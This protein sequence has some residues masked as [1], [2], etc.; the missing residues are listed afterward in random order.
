[1]EFE[2]KCRLCGVSDERFLV[3]SH[4]KPWG[5]S[6]HQERLDSNNGLLLC[7]NHEALFDK[8]YISFDENGIILISN[9]LDEE[10]KVFLNTNESMNIT[11]SERQQKYIKWYQGNIYNYFER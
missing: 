9:S 11:L 2:K 5:Q 10:T 7:L 3:A 4:I 8:G 1:M 6:N